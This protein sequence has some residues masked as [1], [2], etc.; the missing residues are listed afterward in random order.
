MSQRFLCNSR[1]YNFKMT[2]QII[3]NKTEKPNSFEIGVASRR[4]KLYFDTSEDLV[5]QLNKLKEAGLYKED[6]EK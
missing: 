6:N 1:Y 5:Q 4:F 2:E 3:I